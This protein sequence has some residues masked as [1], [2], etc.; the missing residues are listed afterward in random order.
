MA[1]EKV[2]KRTKGEPCVERNRAG[3]GRIPA[4]NAPRGG[5]SG[6][7]IPPLVQVHAERGKNTSSA[8]RQKQRGE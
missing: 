5:F 4:G 6:K 8:K 3:Q 2:H 1:S 7:K